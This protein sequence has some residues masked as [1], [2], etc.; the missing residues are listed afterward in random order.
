MKLAI[1]FATLFAGLFAIASENIPHGFL[2][3]GKSPDKYA[4]EE[5]EKH[6]KL[7]GRS[8]SRN[9][10]SR[11]RSQGCSRQRGGPSIYVLWK[12]GRQ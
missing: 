7:I 6:L 11:G 10:C 8:R 4:R 1:L 2:I 5:L 9:S 12:E 3:E